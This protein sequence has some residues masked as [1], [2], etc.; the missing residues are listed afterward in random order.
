MADWCERTEAERTAIWEAL[1]E[2]F[3]ELGVTC[4]RLPWTT[5]DIC[6]FVPDRLLAASGTWV[7]GVV[8]A[9]AEFAAKPGGTVDA[10][11]R[12]DSI[13]AVTN[14]GALRFKI[15]DDVR[16]LTFDRPDTPALPIVWFWP[17][18]A[19]V[20]A[21]RSRMLFPIWAKTTARFCPRTGTSACSI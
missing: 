11:N 13:V 19:S 6:D 12:D 18:N 16:A 4:R 21:C 15:N 10:V 8:G 14:S 3:S 17:L 9:V 5:D 20:A 2:R 7:V 1:P